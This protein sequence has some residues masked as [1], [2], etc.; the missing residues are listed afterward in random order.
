MLKYNR[1]IKCFYCHKIHGETT[2]VDLNSKN[3]IDKR[4]NVCG[5]CHKQKTD[6]LL[7]TYAHSS[8]LGFNIY[9]LVSIF[10][11]IYIM[12]S[13]LLFAFL[14]LHTI[15][16]LYNYTSNHKIYNK[17]LVQNKYIHIQSVMFFI[18]NLL[19]WFFI[20]I[21]LFNSIAL[22]YSNIF[23]AKIIL[24]YF[25][26]INVLDIN[27]KKFSKILIFLFFLYIYYTI[28]IQLFKNYSKYKFLNINLMYFTPKDFNCFMAI[29]KWS[30]GNAPK[31][32]FNNIT[33]WQ[34]LNFWILL[35]SVFV[36]IMSGTIIW[37]PN[38]FISNFSESLFNHS[39][40]LHKNTAIFIVFFLFTSCVCDLYLNI[41]KTGFTEFIFNGII[42]IKNQKIFNR[43]SY[44][45]QIKTPLFIN[46]IFIFYIPNEFFLFYK[47]FNVIS[48]IIMIL[49][50]NFTIL[51]IFIDLS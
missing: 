49:F 6:N 27:H 43:L 13:L 19:A 10:I 24:K 38:F 16:L 50:I 37:F 39:I 42:P 20:I 29:V 8:Y 30:L 22:F 12:I 11:Y 33:Y 18:I 45:K 7:F 9:S 25:I 14:F 31:P 32:E 3:Y 21:F 15:I 47:W 46:S 1:S 40:M 4:I 34:K 51:G 44:Y 26:N 41:T 36:N 17:T 35:L 2:S 23:W 48:L 5:V 28:Y